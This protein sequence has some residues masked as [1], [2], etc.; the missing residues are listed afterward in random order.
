[1]LYQ[2]SYADE[3]EVVGEGQACRHVRGKGPLSDSRACQ[4]RGLLVFIIYFFS[5]VIEM[6]NVHD[7]LSIHNEPRVT[8]PCLCVGPKS[9]PIYMHARVEKRKDNKQKQVLITK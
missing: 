3:V 2:P 9:Q 1:M 7:L 8:C 5:D 4:I 6:P